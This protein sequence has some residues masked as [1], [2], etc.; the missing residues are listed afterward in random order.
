MSETIDWT[1][2]ALSQEQKATLE[3]TKPDELGWGEWIMALA[4][5]NDVGGI[6]EETIHEAVKAGMVAA[7]ED[8]D[9]KTANVMADG[10]IAFVREFKDE[11]PEEVR[12]AAREGTREA[13]EG[14][15]VEA[16]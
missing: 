10:L 16:E 9:V 2:V 7:G 1:T 5:E 3:A 12:E 11:F 15:E 13:L 14:T 4:G 8:E 6:D